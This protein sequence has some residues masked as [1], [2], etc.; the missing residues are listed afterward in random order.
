MGI[1]GNLATMPLPDVLQWIGQGR[2]TGVLEVRSARGITKRAFFREGALCASS[3]SD[4]REF[5]GQFL[6]A[7][8]LLTEDQLHMAME[9]QARTG[10]MLGRILVQVGILDEEQLLA[11][12]TT[13][14]EEGVYD[15]FFWEE[16]EFHFDDLPVKEEAGPPLALGVMGLVMEGIRRKDEWDRIRTVIPSARSILAPAEDPAGASALENEELLR[17]Y[18]AADGQRSLEELALELRASEFQLASA[19]FQLVQAGLLR[20]VG[21]KP[22]VERLPPGLVPE[23]LCAEAE[24]HLAGGHKEEAT[25]LLRLALRTDPTYSRARG[26]LDK[27][28]TGFAEAFFRDVAPPTAV[29]ELTVPMTH[30][31]GYALSPQEGFLATRV[32][33]AWDIAAILKVSPIPQ[34]E[35]LQALKKLLDLKILVIKPPR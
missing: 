15:L 31:S 26:L 10:V 19:A 34:T 16:G 4:P 2:K 33:G 11:M 25:K 32:N 12:L 17:V 8:G 22:E 9:T 1:R 30:L 23:V 35:A 27:A 20:V 14:A 29:P 3:S 24:R 6:I 18:V 21:E 5:L 13:K 7:N 28:E